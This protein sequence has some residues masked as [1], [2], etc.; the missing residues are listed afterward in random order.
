MQPLG[1]ILVFFLALQQGSG[2]PWPQT[3]PLAPTRSVQ[4]PL[5]SRQCRHSPWEWRLT[6]AWPR[7]CSL[8][9]TSRICI[10]L[11]LGHTGLGRLL[12]W[13]SAAVPLTSIRF[14]KKH[15][16]TKTDS[17]SLSNQVNHKYLYCHYNSADAGKWRELN[18]RREN[19]YRKL[20]VVYN[21]L[22]T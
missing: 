4:L 10:S 11:Q 16:M 7:L 5:W 14:I 12:L 18:E 3:S 19:V 8:L 2:T 21:S 1:M 20:F 17:A 22:R 13:A 6:K 15:H 9:S